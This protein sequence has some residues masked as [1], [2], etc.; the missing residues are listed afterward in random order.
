MKILLPIDGSTLAL[1][2]VR[3]AVRM[4]QD[5]LQASV[6]LAN[7]QEPA[8]FYEIV[9]AHDPDVL[10]KVSTQAGEHQLK[11]AEDLL[12]AAQISFEIEIVQGD[13]AHAIVDIAE[14]YA[15]DLVVMG[16]HA[17]GA[18]RSALTGSVVN[19]VLQ[20]CPVPVLCVKAAA[21]PEDGNF[22]PTAPADLRP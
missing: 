15:C 21:V 2:A 11:S 10:A 1:E 7:V 18:L 9:V 12:M 8:S 5:G 22:V 6:V 13:P 20:A 17:T 3:F 16:S 19:D 4:V 14:R